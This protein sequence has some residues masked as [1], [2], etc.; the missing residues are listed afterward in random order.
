MRIEHLLDLD[1]I[2]V[3]AAAD[4]HVLLAVD[5]VAKALLVQFGEIAGFQPA[6]HERLRG[7]LGLVPIAPHHVRSLGPQLADLAG[8]QRLARGADDAHVAN[9]NRGA[10]AFRAIEIILG[11]MRGE[12]GGCFRHA[13]A[14]AGARVRKRLLDAAHEL[15]SGRR[16]A[17]GHRLQRG[18]VILAAGGMLDQLPGDG[19]H[20]AGVSAALALD[21]PHRGF[22]I[23]AMHQHDLR[24]LEQRRDHDRLAAGGVKERHH[25]QI[26]ARLPAGLGR[27]LAAAHARL[28][29]RIA[30]GHDGGGRIAV[31]AERALGMAG[32]A[33]RVE[34]RGIVVGIEQDLRRRA[35][36]QKLPIAHAADN[37][38]EL[39][40]FRM[41]DLLLVATDVD[42]LEI[43]AVRQMLDD[44]LEA[45]GIRERDFG[46]G[47]L[48]RIFE[49]RAG[50]P[51]IERRGDRAGKQR[52][53]EGRGPFG[54]IAHGDRD[55]V[56]FAHARLDQRIGE[57]ER[58][59]R[60][61]PI[62]Q[63]LL[64]IDQKNALAVRH[65]GQ[66]HLA[67][68]RRRMLPDPR[69]HA[70]NELLL[71]LEARARGGEDRPGFGERHGRPRLC[72]RG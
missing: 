17:V 48:Q 64:L 11:L 70:A 14:E 59:A 31:R 3:L 56:A 46:P 53:E 60:E 51:C 66:E 26:R 32:G 43:R 24:A 54:Q 58:R 41:R 25:E 50:P 9:R 47:I 68:G 4:Q 61:R 30:A 5:D 38:L 19:R 16:P 7:G 33:G 63:A 45:L 52:A 18:E 69:P 62:A 44:A 27:R 49:L 21:Q 57:G 10:A 35:V 42:A 1:R 22:G 29:Q 34:D 67:Q 40:H 8:R 55:A 2:D 71:H 20:A 72:L 6:V 12:G 28:R 37:I 13:P 15:G 36:R 23:P 65:A 39:R